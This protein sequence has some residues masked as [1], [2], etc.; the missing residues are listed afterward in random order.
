MS[1]IR[2]PNIPGFI[3]ATGAPGTRFPAGAT[4]CHAHVF[5]PQDRF[6]YVANAAYIP[7]DAVTADYVGM[8]KNNGCARGVLVQPSVYGTDNSCMVDALRSGLH[9]LRGIAVVEAGISDGELEDLHAAGVRG[10]RINLAS[11]TEGLT[12]ADGERL[13]PRLKELGWHLQFYLDLPKM[14]EAEARLSQLAIN[15]VIDHFARCPAQDGVDAP[16]FQALR[17][18][19]QRDNCWAKIM[20]P[21]FISTN[22]PRYPEVTP[23]ARALVAAA[24]DRIV[25][26]TDWPHPGARALMPQDHVLAD[27]LVEWVPDEAQRR[28]VLVDNP[29]RLYGF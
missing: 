2:T 22:A 28:R 29:Q 18:L 20:G 14:P 3:P 13:A 10:V 26:G 8:L 27:L 12:L 21:Y 24:P 5:G 4:D 9:A 23:L 11:E 6:P 17:R 15:M 16:P 1:P 7:P 25:W 19:V